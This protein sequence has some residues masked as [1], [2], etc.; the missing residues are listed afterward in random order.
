MSIF[1]SNHEI[2]N[3]SRSGQRPRPRSCPVVVET[4]YAAFSELANSALDSWPAKNNRS[5]V[6]VL[7]VASL[8]QPIRYGPPKPARL[9][10]ELISAIAPAAAVPDSQAVGSVQNTP[11]VQNTPIAATTSATIVMTGSLMVLEAANANAVSNSGAPTCRTRSRE[12]SECRAHR[13]IAM[14]PNT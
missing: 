3:A 13:I 5:P 11:K 14:V 12:A 1:V 7:P 6:E 4:D 8:T 10:I 9:P 2:V